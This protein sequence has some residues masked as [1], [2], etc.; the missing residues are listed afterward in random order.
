M[1]RLFGSIKSTPFSFGSLA[2][3][4]ILFGF[5][6]FDR[7]NCSSNAAL[8]WF[9]S[10]TWRI[11]LWKTTI[12]VNCWLVNDILILERLPLLHPKYPCNHISTI[13]FGKVDFST[14]VFPLFATGLGPLDITPLLQ[15]PMSLCISLQ[16]R[17]F[18]TPLTPWNP[19]HRAN[20]TPSM[21]VLFHSQSFLKQEQTLLIQLG[22]IDGFIDVR[23]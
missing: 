11:S 22:E 15:N 17:S 5:S 21:I 13:N 9:G 14:F 7:E 12:R 1:G 16:V 23:S 20:T 2:S 18:R 8:F 10:K 4:L 19:Y 6:I 3:F